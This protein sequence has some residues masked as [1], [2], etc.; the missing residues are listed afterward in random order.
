MALIGQLLILALTIYSWII[1]LEVIVDWLIIFNVINVN[2]DKAQ[3][4]LRLLKK[5]TKP[6]YSKIRKYVPPIGGLDLCPLIILLGIWVLQSLIAKI[7][8]SYA[9]NPYL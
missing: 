9:M 7:M 3:N 5:A 6:V 1:I 2:N 8:F 4:L